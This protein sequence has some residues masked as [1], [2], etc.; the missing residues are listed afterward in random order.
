MKKSPSAKLGII[1]ISIILIMLKF[2]L[3][4]NKIYNLNMYRSLYV[5]KDVWK[6]LI[7]VHENTY[8]FLADWDES[9]TSHAVGWQENQTNN[10]LFNEFHGKD[11]LITHWSLPLTATTTVWVNT[12]FL[13]FCS[14]SL[15]VLKP[16][17]LGN[18]CLNSIS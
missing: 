4:L 8:F 7:S 5:N 3:I 18:Y 13:S 12:V 2:M 9:R 11:N 6:L 17:M 10:R 15:G 1:E 16:A 14:S